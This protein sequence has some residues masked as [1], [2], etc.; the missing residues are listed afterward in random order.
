MHR[1]LVGLA[2]PSAAFLLAASVPAHSQSVSPPVQV[3]QNA[4][5]QSDADLMRHLDQLTRRKGY[6]SI[7]LGYSVCQN[8]GLSDIGGNCKVYQA[9][10]PDN[11]GFIHAFN[12]YDDL[13]AGTIKIILYK[14]NNATATFYMLGLDS[15]LERAAVEK[16]SNGQP[17]WTQ[18][19]NDRAMAGLQRELAYWRTKQ[20]ELA[21]EPDR[22]D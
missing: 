22:K 6:K 18:I 7:E 2:A 13:G 11:A 17:V 16:T 15:V 1:V 21:K 5:R 8:L 3:T 12:S 10:Y 4:A 14:R 20:T 19:P 9:P